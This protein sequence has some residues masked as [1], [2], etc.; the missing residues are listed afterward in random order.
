[1]TTFEILTKITLEQLTIEF[2]NFW[3]APL[4]FLNKQHQMF[5]FLKT[6]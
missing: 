6:M 5:F 2:F 1:M 4:H 3:K